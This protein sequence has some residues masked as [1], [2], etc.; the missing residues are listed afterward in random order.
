MSIINWLRD[1]AP[2]FVV[3]LVSMLIAFF[4][5]EFVFVSGATAIWKILLRLLRTSVVLIIPVLLLPFTCALLRPL[6]SRSGRK[7]VQIREE[8]IRSIHLVEAWVVRPL[9]GIGLSMLI[10][11]KLI[12][13]LQIYTGSKINGSFLLPSGGFILGKFITTTAIFVGTSILL[14]F[15]W[16]LD[17]LGI[18]HF[19]KKTGEIR[20]IGKYLG[21]LLPTVF[22]FYGLMNLYGEYAQPLAL[23]YVTQMAV[24]LYPPFVMFAVFHHRYMQKREELLLKNLKISGHQI[25]QRDGERGPRMVNITGREEHE[26][27]ID[28]NPPGEHILLSRNISPSIHA[29]N[30]GG[31]HD[32]E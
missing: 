23:K 22:G 6:L 20:M 11:T 25:M 5:S 9:Q 16:T 7:L 13:V 31:R 15:L 32:S 17:D 8:R 29:G 14:S 10:A 27:P 4:V 2:A 28:Y 30:R 3:L 21:A 19:N 18:R 1:A 12:S 26:N 24:V